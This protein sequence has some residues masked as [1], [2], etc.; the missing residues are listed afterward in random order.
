MVQKYLSALILLC[1]A[2]VGCHS[3]VDTKKVAIANDTTVPV[4]Y[5]LLKDYALCS[6]LMYA[7]KTDTGVQHDISLTAYK[8]ISDESVPFYQSIDSLS[9]LVVR[10]VEPAQIADYGGKKP[11]I[12]S[13]I[14][15]SQSIRLDSLLR[16][17]DK[18]NPDSK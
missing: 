3:K 4:K 11:Y 18:A 10:G 2:V 1:F 5:K 9:K 8:E 12:K 13:C 16:A 17:L 15:Y 7:F 6:C 14:E